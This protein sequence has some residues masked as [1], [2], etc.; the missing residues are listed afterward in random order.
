MLFVLFVALWLLPASRVRYL[1][2]VFSGS[3][4]TEGARFFGAW[5]VIL[6]LYSNVTLV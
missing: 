1:I 3:S 5:L 2:L 4:L 6:N